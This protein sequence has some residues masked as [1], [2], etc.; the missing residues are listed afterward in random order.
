MNVAVFEP[1]LI[2]TVAGALARAAS[3]EDSVT[4][5][6]PVGAPPLRASVPSD[7]PPPATVVG[8]SESDTRFTALGGRFARALLNDSAFPDTIG[9]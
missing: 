4:T 3:L 8:A 6:P 7:V 5:A 9:R 2:V 1:A